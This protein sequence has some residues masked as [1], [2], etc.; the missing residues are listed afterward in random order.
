MNR[1][2]ISPA[3]TLAAT[4]VLG[5]TLLPAACTAGSEAAPED[6]AAPATDAAALTVEDPWAKAVDDGMTAVFGTLTNTSGHDVRLVSAESAA[7]GSTELHEFVDEGG[8]PVM[9]EAGDGLLVPAETSFTLEPGGPHVMLLGV[10]DPLEPGEE[11]TV[12]VT[13]EDGSELE[14]TAPVR[15][16]DGAN[17]SYGQ[18][19][20]AQDGSMDSMDH[21]DQDAGDGSDHGEDM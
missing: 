11:V 19:G 10:T 1:S 6:G 20:D 4:A 8:S 13:A 21:S 18:D 16:F 17:E 5:L 14:I 7:A 2:T 9:Q 15:S 12:A 3:R